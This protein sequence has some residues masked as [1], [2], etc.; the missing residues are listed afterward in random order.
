MKLKYPKITF[1]LTLLNMSSDL[2]N[3]RRELGHWPITGQSW[4][5]EPYHDTLVINWPSVF[6]EII[7][8]PPWIIFRDGNGNFGNGKVKPKPKYLYNFVNCSWWFCIFYFHGKQQFMTIVR[9]N[10]LVDRWYLSDISI[11]ETFFP[12]L[13]YLLSWIIFI[14]YRWAF[15]DK[16]R[17]SSVPKKIQATSNAKSLRLFTQSAHTKTIFSELSIWSWRE[18]T[19]WP[20]TWKHKFW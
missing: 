19:P 5:T 9:M 14:F 7:L 13:N 16:T 6:G 2:T 8:L 20:I 15:P 4:D 12:S 3:E 18:H 10:L 1:T 11:L 17:R